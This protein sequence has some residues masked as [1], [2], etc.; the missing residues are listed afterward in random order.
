MGGRAGR[1][2]EGRDRAAARACEA[3]AVLA[4]ALDRAER[5]C[6]TD[7]LDGPAL[8]AA[9]V[10]VFMRLVYLRAAAEYGLVADAGTRSALVSLRARLRE[11]A[12][13]GAILPEQYDAW[14]PLVALFRRVHAGHVGLP[15]DGGALFDPACCPALQPG[16]VSSGGTTAPTIDDDAVLRLLDTIM[17]MGGGDDGAP[18]LSAETIGRLYETLCDDTAT[19]AAEPLLALAG[20]A[21]R[22]PLAPLAHL[23]ALGDESDG[24]LLDYL[25]RETGRARSRLASLLTAGRVHDDDTA[26]ISGVPAAW[27]HDEGLWRRVRPFVALLRADTA[28]TPAVI[29]AGEV[30]VTRGI[31][32]RRAGAHYTPRAVAAEIVRYTL[33][34]VAYE[35]PSDG[36]PRAAWRL[37]SSE[38]LLSLKVCDMS[39]GCGI[40]LVEACRYLAARVVEA[41]QREARTHT[42]APARGEWRKG[43]GGFAPRAG[44]HG[45]AHATHLVAGRCLYGVDKDPVAVELAKLALWIEGGGRKAEGER[46]DAMWRGYD[47]RGID[48]IPFLDHRLRCGDALVGEPAYFRP[49]PSALRP[50][51]W[52]LAFPEVFG[53]GDGRA[54]FDAMVGNPPFGNAIEGAT[55]RDAVFKRYAAARYAPFAAGAGDYCLLF[56]ARALLHLLAPGGAYGWLSPTALLSDHKPWQAWVH[57]YARPTSLLLYPVD[58]FPAARIRT[59]GYCGRR[60]R[61]AS[62]TVVDYD[63]Y[64]GEGE[65]SPR[66]V[67]WPARLDSWYEVTRRRLSAN[68]ARALPRADEVTEGTAVPLVSLPVRLHAGCAAGVAYDLAPLV[69]DSVEEPGARLVTTGALDRYGCS[70]GQAPVRYLSKTYKYPRWPAPAGAPAGVAR[71]LARQQ[72]PKILIGGLTAVVEGWLDAAGDAAGVVSTWAVVP[73]AGMPLDALYALLAVLNSATFSRLYMDRH[74]ARSMSGKQ[75]T[76]YKKA[77]C[78]MP[79]PAALQRGL[80]DHTCRAWASRER[81]CLDTPAGLLAVCGAVGRSLQTMAVDDPR[82][83]PLDRLGHLAAALLYGDD[84]AGAEDDYLW[85]CEHAGVPPNDTPLD[86][87]VALLCA[88]THGRSP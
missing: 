19:R 51:H 34:Q 37:R 64:H 2:A 69:A 60:G 33:D 9:A 27:R 39:M 29:P 41:W 87:L 42:E 59:T 88:A 49:P 14:P 20:T 63:G 50:F 13:R 79:C 25:C 70:W 4:R 36:R 32:R 66:T 72:G 43:T 11:S 18:V 17:A 21:R 23:E 24:A 71:A 40:F 22:E 86:D 73:D 61:A 77:L 8:Y 6:G 26:P 67:P 68:S 78:D 48:E 56:W 44:E 38:E 74:G 76:M 80:R 12:A 81:P 58:L 83:R 28:A 57:Q 53:R 62:V 65:P 35:E 75:T 30:Y 45:L 15:S 47:R 46:G 52:A 1:R 85:W 10:I 5:T 7:A 82:Y 3:V 31:G 55:A 84:A 16:P 54:G